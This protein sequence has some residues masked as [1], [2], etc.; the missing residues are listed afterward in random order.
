MNKTATTKAAKAICKS[1]KLGN[2]LGVKR[3]PANNKRI[4]YFEESPF[5]PWKE[6]LSMSMST[7]FRFFLK[8]IFNLKM[9]KI[10]E[11]NIFFFFWCWILQWSTKRTQIHDQIE[12]DRNIEWIR[13][14][15]GLLGFDVHTPRERESLKRKRIERKK[16]YSMSKGL[17]AEQW[18]YW[19]HFDDVLHYN[20]SPLRI[21]GIVCDR[22]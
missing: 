10:R 11:K 21:L 9:C 7:S 22:F 14:N 18:T 1:P 12:L 13:M 16:T 8:V 2:T 15:F 17:D 6:Q 5:F 4:S 20:K 3:Q 19:I